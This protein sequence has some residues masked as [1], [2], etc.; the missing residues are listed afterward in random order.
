MEGLGFRLGLRQFIGALGVLLS[1]WASR[2]AE[3]EAWL[4]TR[5]AQHCGSCH[6]VGRKNLK[7]I[8]RR[9]TL[10][11]QGCHVNP[12]GGGLRSFYGK[13]TEDRILRTFRSDQ[14][15]NYKTAAP[16]G[17][18]HYGDEAAEGGGDDDKDKDKKDKGTAHKKKKPS[19]KKGPG[20]RGYPLVEVENTTVAEAMFK[21][22]GREY[23]VVDRP[24]YM[25]QIPAGDPYRLLD[26]SKT[27]GGG[28]L[29][30]QVSQLKRDDQDP[31]FNRFFMSADLALRHRPLYR[32][33]HFVYEFRALGSPQMDTDVDTF[34]SSGAQTRSAYA[35]LEDLPYN[36][37]VMAGYYRPLFGNFVPDHYQLAQEMTSAAMT[38]TSKNYAGNLFNAVS[39]G[40]APNVPY[41]NFHLI[42][43]RMGEKGDRTH[44][45]AANLGLRFVTLGGSINY[46]YWRTED[47]RSEQKTDVEM[48]SIG[49]AAMLWRTVTSLELVSVKR[50]V[51]TDSMRQGGVAT[52]DTYTR[53]WREN[54]FTLMLA[55]ANTTVDIKPGEETQMKAGFRGFIVPGVDAMI[56]YENREQTAKDL[57]LGTSTKRKLSGIAS[58]LH[59]FF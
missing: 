41:A 36:I 24:E 49:G 7:P 57:D 15:G 51:S 22:D 31:T 21:R 32:K 55:K 2:G 27:D 25:A 26:E 8:D 35:M 50:E 9:C 11:C 6:A 40:T 14:L 17:K 12:N 59:L 37:F 16:L 10:S 45:I 18:Q 42:N 56:Y 48:H 52:L 29:R 47:K 39:I 30:Y 28:D 58:Q 20:K 13:W 33:L 34:A 3:A 19:H 4:S 54:Y 5:Y 23:Q 44:G 38:G 46:S 1:L 53:L 43:N